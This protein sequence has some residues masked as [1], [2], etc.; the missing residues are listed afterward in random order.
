[1]RDPRRLRATRDNRADELTIGP[2]YQ[3]H[4]DGCRGRS[5]VDA[6]LRN[7]GACSLARRARLDRV[8]CEARLRAHPR[9]R[10]VRCARDLCARAPAA[11]LRREDPGANLAD[12]RFDH[13]LPPLRASGDRAHAAGRLP[14]LLRLQG[15]RA[16]PQAAARGLLRVLLIR[17][18]AVPARSSGALR[19]LSRKRHR[20]VS[21]LR[22]RRVHNDTRRSRRE[23]PT[24]LTDESAIA[25]AAMIGESRM[26]KKG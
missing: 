26:P 18:G 8:R 20:Q 17:L 6:V 12:L 7:T 24:T 10:S 3:A 22:A 1:M 19:R 25:A 13:H 2:E 9:V 5:A 4:V 15:L 16:T 23:F 14:V 21:G 11:E